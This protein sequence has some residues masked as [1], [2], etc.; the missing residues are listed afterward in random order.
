MRRLALVGS[1]FSVV[2][3]GACSAPPSTGTDLQPP[4]TGQG[5]QYRMVSTLASGVETERCQFFTAPPEGLYI[6]RETVRYTPGSHHV[7][8]FTTRY[9]VIPDTN[10]HGVVIDKTGVNE[11]PEGAGNDYDIETVVAGAQSANA[12]DIIS[13]PPDTALKVKGGTIL[14]MN[15]HYLNASPKSLETDARINLYTIPAEQV[16]RDAGIIFFYNPIIRVPALGSAV[17]RM[18]CPVNR[19]YTV[20]NLQTHMH[21]RGMGG[22]AYITDRNLNRMEKIYESNSW[23]NPAV[24]TFDQGRTITTGTLLDYHCNYENPEDRTVLQGQTTKDEMCMLI[25]AYTPRNTAFEF[26]SPDGTS[27]LRGFAG[28]FIGNGTVSCMDSVNCIDDA[29]KLAEGSRFDKISECVVSS[30]EKAAKPFN[31]TLR[32]MLTQ[33]ES[34]CSTECKDEASVACGDCARAKCAAEMS[35]CQTTACN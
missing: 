1:L 21:K 31:D 23:E 26:C 4:P 13:L 17:A 2:L 33:Y 10:R 8:L 24:K 30:C 16:K 12:A 7:L 28:T 5:I 6:N 3:C 19:E 22:E 14:V 34:G 29:R 18:A 15:T 11:C 35:T 9:T 20:F 25:G 27:G 32:C